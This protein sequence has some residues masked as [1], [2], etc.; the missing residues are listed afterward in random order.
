MLNVTLAY[1]GMLSFLLRVRFDE[2]AM[3]LIKSTSSKFCFRT[4]TNTNITDICKG[5]SVLLFLQIEK[6]LVRQMDQSVLTSFPKENQVVLKYN[7]HF[8]GENPDDFDDISHYF[9]QSQDKYFSHK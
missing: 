7:L 9:R 2:K 5:F 1:K 6:S 8:S 3:K 4:C